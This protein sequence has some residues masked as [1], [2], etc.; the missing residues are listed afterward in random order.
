[1]YNKFGS[2]GHKYKRLCDELRPSRLK[3]H[4]GTKI[5]VVEARLAFFRRKRKHI[6]IIG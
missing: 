6:S 3:T 4:G 5:T 1:M 2:K